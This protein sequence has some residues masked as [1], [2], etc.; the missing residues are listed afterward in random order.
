MAAATA[1]AA[2]TA[3]AAVEAAVAVVRLTSQERGVK[4]SAGRERCAAVKIQT[5]FRG[6][7][8]TSGFLI[9]FSTN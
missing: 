2:D 1:A 4:L 8:V 5:V 7:S 6:Y 9:F 3:V